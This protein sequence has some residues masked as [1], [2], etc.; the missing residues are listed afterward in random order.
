MELRKSW[1]IEASVLVVLLGL[2][3]IVPSNSVALGYVALHF[4]ILALGLNIVLG[5]TGLLDLGAAGFV[6]VGAYITAISMSRFGWPPLTVLPLT[7]GFG[8]FAGIL[9]GIPTLRH[10]L[11]YFAILTLGFAELV[12]LTIRNWP[13]VTKGSFGYSGIPA[14]TFPFFPEPFR[15]TPPIG[16]YF[17]ALGVL[18]LTYAF[19]VWL[20][21]TALGRYFHVIKH[22]EEVGQA[23]GINIFAVKMAAFGFSAAFL[24]I[25]GFFWAI[26]Q[27]SI[28]WT[29]FGVVLSFMLVSVVV[30]GGIG[31]PR[32]IMLGAVLVGCSLEIIRRMLTLSGLPQDTRFLI[33]SVALIA[34]IHLRSTGIMVDR[35]SWLKQINKSKDSADKSKYPEDMAN[36]SDGQNLLE[37]SNVAKTFGAVI[38]LDGFSLKLASKECVALIGPNGSGKTTLLNCICGLTKQYKG[39]IRFKGKEISG[40]ASYKIARAGIGRSFQDLSVFDDITPSDNVFLTSRRASATQVNDSLTRFGVS[41]GTALTSSLAYGSKKALD[42]ARLFVEPNRLKVVLLDEPTAGLSQQ[43]VS[44]MVVTLLE[45]RRQT[46]VAMV[47]VSHDV[48]FLEALDVDRVAVLQRG[49]LFKEGKFSEIRSDEEVRRLFWG[50]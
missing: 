50:E 39:S 5:W 27:R 16:F 4:A 42:L 40:M 49:R 36:S 23:Y 47:V 10:R 11:D 30:V 12:G 32:G 25:G 8:F 26:Y 29:E 38:A 22:N 19:V 17:L 28:I 7:F 31:N 37:I 9:L 3:F 15:T 2:P 44:D 43:E 6:A 33:F 46:R 48:R 18:T 1:T 21:S 24:A 45:L 14:T 20:R 41:D 13:A 35:P 34:F